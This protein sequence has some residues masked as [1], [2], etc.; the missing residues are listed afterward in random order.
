MFRREQRANIRREWRLWAGGGASVIAFAVWSVFVGPASG[1]FLAGVS[2]ALFGVFFT[3]FA[4]GGHISTFRWWLGAEG[5]RLTGREIETLPDDWHCIHDLEHVHG[6]YDHVLVGPPGVFL[7]DSKLLHGEVVAGN[8]RLRSG[9]VVFPG[10][11]FRGSAAH[12]HAALEESLGSRAHW[13][14]AIVVI[15]GSFAQARHF[16]QNVAY[17]EGAGLVEYLKSL[18]ER[19]NGPQ[20]AAYVAAL[21]E[22]RRRLAAPAPAQAAV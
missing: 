19:L 8:D 12:I 17:L 6:N 21:E 5:E 1:R 10:A 11:Q 18:P 14:N 20:C 3:V 15:W 2:G 16:E 4:L 13:V 22:V 9:R 7:L